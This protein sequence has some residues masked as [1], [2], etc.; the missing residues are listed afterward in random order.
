MGT[1]GAVQPLQGACTVN[2]DFA[3][4]NAELSFEKMRGKDSFKILMLSGK[5]SHLMIH[6]WKKCPSVGVACSAGSI[7]WKVLSSDFSPQ[8]PESDQSSFL[9]ALAVPLDSHPAC[10]PSAV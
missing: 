2:T 3:F 5:V 7:F 1:I 9:R 6:E 4:Y 10:I 8:M